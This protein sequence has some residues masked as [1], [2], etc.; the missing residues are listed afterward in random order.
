MK[1]D[2]EVLAEVEAKD[3]IQGIKRPSLGG[4]CTMSNWLRTSDQ[5]C[6]KSSL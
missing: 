6:V 4:A 5:A 2:R 3:H 1:E